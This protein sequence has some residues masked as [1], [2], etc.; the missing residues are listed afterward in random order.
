MCVG[1]EQ[2]IVRCDACFLLPSNGASITVQG[3]FNLLRRRGCS[4]ETVWVTQC[5]GRYLTWPYCR[6]DDA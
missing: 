1:A 2:P 4:L 3:P 6:F 5:L